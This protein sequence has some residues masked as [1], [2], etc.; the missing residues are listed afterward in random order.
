VL[1]QDGIRYTITFGLLSSDFAAL[2]G[3]VLEFY[4]YIEGHPDISFV[5][6]HKINMKNI[7]GN[8]YFLIDDL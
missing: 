1:S 7:K 2:D 3:E 5:H 6:Q 4:C 8:Q